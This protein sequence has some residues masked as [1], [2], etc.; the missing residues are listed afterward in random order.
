MS[1]SKGPDWFN[2]GDIDKMHMLAACAEGNIERVRVFLDKGVQVDEFDDDRVT[3][4]QISAAKGHVKLIEFL[5]SFDPD[6]ERCNVVGF[7]PLLHACREGHLES[8][9]LLIQR[10][11]K[12]DVTTFTGASPLTLACAG[13]HF[14]LVKYLLSFKDVV[15]INPKKH[16]VSPSP[17]MAAAFRNQ[18]VIASCLVSRGAR[19]DYVM[20]Q[21]SLDIMSCVIMCGS[22]TMFSTLLDLGA[23]PE[24]IRNYKNSNIDDLVNICGRIDIWRVL[25][26]HKRQLQR[27]YPSTVDIRKVIEEGRIVEIIDL[28]ENTEKWTKLNDDQSPLMYA[29]IFGQQEIVR[30]IIDS[31]A[32]LNVKEGKLGLTAL[33]IAAI[34][35]DN[36]IIINLLHAGAK[37]NIKCD[38][39]WTALDFAYVSKGVNPKVISLLHKR[40]VNL[41]ITPKKSDIGYLT[42]KKTE[43]GHISSDI[44]SSGRITWTRFLNN[45]GILGKPEPPED[46]P[47][48]KEFLSGFDV[49][50]VDFSV[51][52]D[53]FLTA[54]DILH[55]FSRK[56]EKTK[57]NSIEDYMTMI[58]NF[59]QCLFKNGSFLKPF[60]LGIPLNG[61]FGKVSRGMEEWTNARE[62]D[63]DGNYSTSQKN[64]AYMISPQ[65]PKA[66]CYSLSSNY[67]ESNSMKKSGTSGH[68]RVPRKPNQLPSSSYSN[69][70][71]HSNYQPPSSPSAHS[72]VETKTLKPSSLIPYT[73]LRSSS[74][75]SGSQVEQKCVEK[76]QILKEVASPRIS[77]Q[78]IHK[79]SDPGE[80]FI[81][82]RLKSI[83]LQQ[84][85]KAFKEQEVDFQTFLRCD[86]NDIRQIVESCANFNESDVTSIV[87]L[88]SDLRQVYTIPTKK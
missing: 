56:G 71:I 27:Q 11:S 45:F 34:L 52:S 81:Q 73:H 7:T 70:V 46:Y 28:L 72:L 65:D 15:D 8:V 80:D 53:K 17:L 75:Q 18:P 23:K 3:A 26:D 59:A 29:V 85:S 13:G 86:E 5:L 87:R 36:E 32:D 79:I 20:P 47:P 50:N 66:S 69:V 77:P 83:G 16:D 1:A 6:L 55:G 68:L 21:F 60:P 22:A 44:R 33:M 49:G 54:N 74:F 57:E 37:V 48:R 19:V 30:V 84:Y 76:Y 78:R 58:R 62:E 41:S 38:F 4:L 67:S 39:G 88:I 24:A 82:Q 61:D 12:L 40:L 42:P 63:H 25:Q 10:G 35:G 31:K 64:C 51:L 43:F 9:K 2:E 14:E